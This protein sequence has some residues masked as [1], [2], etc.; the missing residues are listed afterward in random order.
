MS[1]ECSNRSLVIASSNAGKI[2]EFRSFLKSFPLIVEAQP[3]GLVVD[4]TGETFAENA[5]IKALQIAE[6]AGK[7]A[8]ADDSGLKVKALNGAPGIYSAR[9]ASTDAKRISRLLSDLKTVV[10]RRA[11]FVAS[12]CIAAP[13]RRRRRFLCWS[14]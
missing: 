8:L 3:Q 4:E 10:D 9:Y 13:P 5:R 12:L 1:K 14:P 6:I 11:Q 7:W 2:S